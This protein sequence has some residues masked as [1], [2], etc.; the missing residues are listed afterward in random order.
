MKTDLLIVGDSLGGVLAAHTACSQGH[1]A[2]LVTQHPW[3]GGQLTSQAVPPDEHRLIEHGG[4][5]ASYR[6]FRNAMHAHYRAQAGFQDRAALTEGCNP[7]D[8]WVSRLCIE[9]A[10]AH[11][12]LRELLQPHIDSGHL[13]L[14]AG[15]AQAVQRE[16]RRI[17]SL[18]IA[19]QQVSAAYVLDATETGELLRLAGLP[20]RLG[21][22]A[23]ADWAEP[24][25][26]ARAEPLDQQPVTW[27]LALRRQTTPGP[28]VQRPPHYEHWRAY[29]VPHYGHK[30]FSD[31]LPGSQPGAV[32]HLPFFA[33]GA[34]LDWWRYRRIVAGHQ[35]Q[36]EREEVSLVNWAQNDY[37]A[38]PLL[39][40]PE[41]PE[42]VG[43][44]A[45]ELSLCFLHWLQT[46]ADGRGY[47][48]LQ[49]APDITG[50]PDGLAQAVY[51][52]E[53]RRLIGLSTLTQVLLATG[54]LEPMHHPRS[55]GIAWYNLDIH[56]TVVSGH[57]LNAKSRPYVLPLGCFISPE[58]DNLLPA[59]KNISA[60][61]L[62]AAS[63]RVHPTEWM[64]G[65]VA[66][67]I[68]SQ[69]LRTG[70]HPRALHD[71]PLAV[72]ALQERL[73]AVG[74]PTEWDPDLIALL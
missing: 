68:A 37:A 24:L 10:A 31:A 39:D 53:S 29:V 63:T 66:G 57:G 15:E 60:T 19:G 14:M 35:W 59:C 54:S 61:H 17:H 33:D 58:I 21:K 12:Y 18:T 4:C 56:P 28:V 64:V 26:P 20:Y 52:R 25:A 50:T 32:A 45:R 34:T 38:V 6:A 9:P 67:L 70:R 62:A 27:V 40:G 1:T 42:A 73:Q 16:D 72:R 47:P 65:E 44:A 69:A 51:V 36:D 55:V 22:E 30:L 41:S 49:P 2:V 3:I 13:Q 71:D 11:A 5:T 74:I 48:E 8:G 43:T 7:G 23:Q 46:E